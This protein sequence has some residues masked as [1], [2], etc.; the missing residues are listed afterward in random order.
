VAV[1]DVSNGTVTASSATPDRVAVRVMA[2]PSSITFEEDELKL[3]VGAVSLS[4]RVIVELV[5]EPAAEAPPPL[6]EPI[7]IIAV[8]E[9][10]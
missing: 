9:P 10:S 4:A 6:T 5:P 8:S 7:L 2:L 1:P 3:T